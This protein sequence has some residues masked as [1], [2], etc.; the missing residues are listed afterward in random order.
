[1][2]KMSLKDISEKMRDIDFA[3]L[4]TRTEGGALAG[5]PMSNNRDV[6]YNGDSYFFA[7]DE[8]RMV[9]DIRHDSQVA[10]TY[11][12][13][14]GVLKVKPF[15][16]TMEGRAELIRD[17]G[18]FAAH[19]NPDLDAWFEQGIDTPGLTLIKVAAERIHYWN[20]G[21]EGEVAIGARPAVIAF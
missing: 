15:F 3:L 11:Q 12:S 16:L 1:M 13:K 9:A 18:S 6:D 7:L 20:G 8:T 5:R 10:L 21:D 17:R 14:S 4:V 19:W 2:G